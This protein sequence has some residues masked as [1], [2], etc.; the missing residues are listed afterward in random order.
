MTAFADAGD[1]AG[2]Y[3][4]AVGIALA[5][6]CEGRDRLLDTYRGPPP[7]PRRPGDVIAA[8]DPAAR[9]RFTSTTLELGSPLMSALPTN[10]TR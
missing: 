4:A 1:A 5:I 3:R 7:T 6:V 10:R 9:Q 8:R 2:A